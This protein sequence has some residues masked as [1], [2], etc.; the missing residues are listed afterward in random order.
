MI[1]SIGQVMLYVNDTENA[2]KFWIDKVGFKLIEE[3][4]NEFEGVK[5]F[6]YVIAPEEKS[7]V[8][9]V[10][11]SKEFVSKVSPEV[12][13]GN[14]SILMSSSDI[15]NTYNMFIK[16]GVKANPIMNVFE[17]KVFNFCDEEENYYAVREV[18]KND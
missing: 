17:G 5:Y 14:P 15:E 7:D 2:K 6:S 10:L 8:Q 18:R 9:F 1:K 11:H 3:L 4:V 16:N 13:L 12:D